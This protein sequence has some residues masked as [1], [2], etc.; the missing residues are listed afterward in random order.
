MSKFIVICGAILAVAFTALVL[1]VNRDRTE[2]AQKE[3]A[4]QA[5]TN[6]Q[7][8]ESEIHIKELKCEGDLV[9]KTS[10]A[11]A[12]AFCH[13]LRRGDWESWAL[14]FPELA[15]ARATAQ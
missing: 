2:A 6:G 15:K 1:I 12:H 11:E 10:H 13:E 9:G 4:A 14:Q 8:A 7:I 5:Q 3:M